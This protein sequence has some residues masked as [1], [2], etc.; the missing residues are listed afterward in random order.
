MNDE[1]IDTLNEVTE[2]LAALIALA[3]DGSRLS[4]L[5]IAERRGYFSLADRLVT[6][7]AELVDALG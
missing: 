2:S 4:D 7:Q 3:G 6:Q 1:H 5:S